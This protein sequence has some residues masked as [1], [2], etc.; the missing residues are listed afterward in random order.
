MCFLLTLNYLLHIFTFFELQKK[1]KIKIKG[2]CELNWEINTTLKKQ[3]YSVSVRNEKNGTYTV[4][5]A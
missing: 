4:S 3:T 1:N 2:N 5:T